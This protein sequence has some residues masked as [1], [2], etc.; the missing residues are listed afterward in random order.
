LF[1]VDCSIAYGS[2]KKINVKSNTHFNFIVVNFF[3]TL[4]NFR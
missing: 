3:K 2:F 4:F 1:K